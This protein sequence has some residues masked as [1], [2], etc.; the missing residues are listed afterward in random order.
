MFCNSIQCWKVDM[1]DIVGAGVI[2]S[3]AWVGLAGVFTYQLDLLACSESLSYF[4]YSFGAFAQDMGSKGEAS[5]LKD[6]N[7][8]YEWEHTKHPG[9][10]K[11]DNELRASSACVGIMILLPTMRIPCIDC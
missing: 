6:N 3:C 10:T 4:G 11:G 5:A 2:I 1:G 9:K 7:G 8:I